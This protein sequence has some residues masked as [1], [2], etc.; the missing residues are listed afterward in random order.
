MSEMD[1]FFPEPVKL[2]INGELD[3]HHFSPREIK[4]LV[5]DYLEACIEKGI[6]DVRIIHGKGT[7]ILRKSVH[8]ILERLPYVVSFQLADESRGSWGATIVVIQGGYK[9]E[10]T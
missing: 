9:R 1:D 2:E 5:P 3:L 4:Y 7:G 10:I 6:F 8:S